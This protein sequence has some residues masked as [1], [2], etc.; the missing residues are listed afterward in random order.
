MTHP[1]VKFMYLNMFNLLKENSP[2]SNGTCFLLYAHSTY[3]P[4][5]PPDYQTQRKHRKKFNM[6]GTHPYRPRGINQ[7]K[8]PLPLNFPPIFS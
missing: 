2:M 7:G 6:K 1:A 8:D 3:S 5:L 4:M